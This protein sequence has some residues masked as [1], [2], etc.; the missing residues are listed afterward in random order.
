M[1][2]ETMTKEKKLTDCEKQLRSMVDNIASEING[3]KPIN[4]ESC[5]RYH[6]L[7]DEEKKDF[8]PTGHDFLDYVYSIKW[9]INQDKS[10]SGAM[11]LVAGG[12][13]NIWVNTEDNQVEGYWGGD[14]YIKYFSD[15]IGLNDACEEL[16]GCC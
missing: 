1:R 16:Y 2:E 14:K 7:S 12:G 11:L 4:P 6:N 5:E 3:D 15:Q 10:Y 13:P 8:Q 9:I